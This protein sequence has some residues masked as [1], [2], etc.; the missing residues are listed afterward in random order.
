M[1]FE[2][3][4]IVGTSI[5]TC[6]INRYDDNTKDAATDDVTVIEYCKNKYSYIITKDDFEEMVNLLNISCTRKN[7]ISKYSFSPNSWN[8]I[9]STECKIEYLI[10]INNQLKDELG[11]VSELF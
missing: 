5:I 10:S 11:K 7:F 4:L 1:T 8:R 3:K 2:K 9:I 6:L